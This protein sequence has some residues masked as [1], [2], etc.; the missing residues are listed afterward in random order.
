MLHNGIL[1]RLALLEKK[2]NQLHLFVFFHI[3]SLMI[4]FLHLARISEIWR[5]T[6]KLYSCLIHVSSDFLVEIHEIINILTYLFF[7]F[8][9]RWLPKFLKEGTANSPEWLSPLISYPFGLEISS[10]NLSFPPEKSYWYHSF[11]IKIENFNR[12]YEWRISYTIMT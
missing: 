6:C 8:N 10:F 12:L 4:A 5:K 1:K 3:L 9:W 2:M 7:F 11:I